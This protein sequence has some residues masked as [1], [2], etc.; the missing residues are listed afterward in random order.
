MLITITADHDYVEDLLTGKYEGYTVE[1]IRTFNHLHFK[2][3]IFTSIVGQL[4]G[5]LEL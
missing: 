2:L 3:V 5:I 1:V 4:P